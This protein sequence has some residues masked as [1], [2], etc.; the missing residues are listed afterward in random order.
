MYKVN[1]VSINNAILLLYCLIDIMPFVATQMKLEVMGLSD[2]SQ[3]QK[4]KCGII[5][6]YVDSQTIELIKP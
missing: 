4:D 3:A 1:M 2:I 6:L 5:S